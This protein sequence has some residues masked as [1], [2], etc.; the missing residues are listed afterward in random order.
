MN[1]IISTDVQAAISLLTPS[2]LR[3][4]LTLFCTAPENQPEVKS[5]PHQTG[6]MAAAPGRTPV[7][8]MLN[9]Q[10]ARSKALISGHA[11]L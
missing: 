10:T 5:S 11:R 8:L 3:M 4:S 7:S 1:G 9:S 2:P 6:S